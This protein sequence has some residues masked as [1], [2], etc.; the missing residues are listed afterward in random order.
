[1]HNKLNKTKVILITTII[2]LIVTLGATLG[3]C[4]YNYHGYIVYKQQYLEDYFDMNNTKNK[5]SETKVENIIKWSASKYVVSPGTIEYRDPV[6]KDA[7]TNSALTDGDALNIG[8]KYENNTLHLPKYFDVTFYVQTFDSYNEDLDKD[9]TTFSYQF[10]F[11][12]I[13]YNTIA[14]GFAPESIYIAFIE[15]IGEDADASLDELLKEK[16]STGTAGGS[17][18]CTAWYYTL[19][20]KDQT[21][22]SFAPSDN[23]ID[24]YKDEDAN[25]RY[26]I[27]RNNV[28]GSDDTNAAFGTTSDLTFAIFY[29]AKD[30]NKIVYKNLV[31]GTYTTQ[32]VNDSLLNKDNFADLESYEI[33][34]GQSFKQESFNAFVTPKLIKDGLLAFVIAGAITALLGFVLTFNPEIEHAKKKPA[35]HNKK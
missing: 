8:A 11:T 31:E 9:E 18:P 33:G 34:Y 28:I 4:L 19:Y 25:K 26:Y 14:D 2:C 22:Y 3:V 35:K 24:A 7:I 21:A 20:S 10:L 30:G 15:G 32:K 16:E 29:L 12:N 27:Y 5:S 23:S 6:T 13:N 1:M 17:N